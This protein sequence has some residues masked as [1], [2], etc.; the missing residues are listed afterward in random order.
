MT[1]VVLKDTREIETVE[2]PSFP[3]SE[4]KLYKGLLFGQMKELEKETSGFKRGI[5]SLRLMI[6]EWNF[7][8]EKS[9]S[10]PITE[11]S[12]DIL[13]VKDLTILLNKIAQFFEVS[14]KKSK[15]VLKK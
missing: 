1:N 15:Q 3:G 14:E 5:V 6:K 10:L 9:D 2:L 12:F 11:D 4:V 13:P 8:D 7:V